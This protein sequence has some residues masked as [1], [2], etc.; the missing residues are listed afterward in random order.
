[1]NQTDYEA[2]SPGSEELRGTIMQG[3]ETAAALKR[4]ARDESIKSYVQTERPVHDALLGAAMRFIGGESLEECLKVAEGLNHS[5]HAVTIDY[6]G[7]STRDERMADEATEEFLRVVEAISQNELDSSVS[8]DL[9]HIGLTVDEE[10]GLANASK[11]CSAAREAGLE[12]M[13]SM[14]GS[15]RTEQV[16]ALY[17][18]L[19]ERFDNVGITLQA[20]LRR[21]PSDLRRAL[22]SPGKVRV[23]KGAFEEPEDVALPRGG[24]LDEAYLS[25][26]QGTIPAGHPISVATHD[27]DVLARVHEY[28]EADALDAGQ[29]EFEMLRGVE[30]ERLE[31]MRG[32]G[33][34]TRVYLPYGL[35]WY[36]YLCHRLAEH[37]PNIYQAIEDAVAKSYLP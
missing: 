35:E 18:R 10:L 20:H 27:P 14:E 17:G 28:I 3:K 25:L 5:G 12:V 4:I 8:L 36:L 19:S 7:E 13:V 29:V 9:S 11:L 1:M 15:E 31:K 2:H 21:T 26:V 6:M 37:P 30:F 33:Y 23:V 16:L 32:L 22:E 34:R 24:R